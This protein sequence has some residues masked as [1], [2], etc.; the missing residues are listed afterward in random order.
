MI[1]TDKLKILDDKFKVN[2][3]QYDLDRESGKIS[4]LLSGQIEKNENLTC[5]NVG[6]KPEV[7]ERAEFEYFLLGKVFNKGLNEKDKKRRTFEKIKKN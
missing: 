3:A 6:Y 7:V 4:G 1:L 5:E 2:Q